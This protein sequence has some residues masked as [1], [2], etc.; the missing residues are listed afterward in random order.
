MIQGLEAEADMI[1]AVEKDETEELEDF[2]FHS[3]IAISKDQSYIYTCIAISDDAIAKYT[4]DGVKWQYN[5]TLENSEK[6]FSLIL[7]PDE[8]YLVGTVSFGFRVWNLKNDRKVQLHLPDGARNVP[9]RKELWSQIVFTKSM[10]F[11][12]GAVR[13]NIYVWDVRVGNLV[14]TLD[15][16]CG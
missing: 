9:Y 6:M 12:V 5:R 3:A 10:A 8:N 16:H 7:S 13:K 4:R 11:I 1:L 2:D 14:K 15:A